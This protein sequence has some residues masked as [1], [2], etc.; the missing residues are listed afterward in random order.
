MYARQVSCESI[1]A[2][3]RKINLKCRQ[4]KNYAGKVNLK[5]YMIHEK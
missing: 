5:S 3:I 2:I 4:E 1:V